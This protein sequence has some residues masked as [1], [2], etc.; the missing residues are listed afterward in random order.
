MFVGHK[1]AL[2]KQ[3]EQTPMLVRWLLVRRPHTP[4][5]PESH[6]GEIVEFGIVDVSIDI[7]AV[8]AGVVHHPLDQESSVAPTSVGPGKRALL[9]YGTK[10]KTVK[11][12]TY[13]L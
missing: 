10:I 11:N 3:N 5:P 9:K 6:H 8:K 1:T 4:P 2:T 12:N 7:V 13:K